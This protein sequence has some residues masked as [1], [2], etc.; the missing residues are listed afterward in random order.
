MQSNGYL[1]LVVPFPMVN[2]KVTGAGTFRIL[3]MQFSVV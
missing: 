1:K 3:V 2:P